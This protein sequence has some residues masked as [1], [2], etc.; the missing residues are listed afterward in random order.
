MFLRYIPVLLFFLVTSVAAQT[1]LEALHRDAVVVDG[2]NDIL[3]RVMSGGEMESRSTHGHSDLPRFRQGGLDV[4]VFSVWVPSREKGDKAW[5]FALAEIDTLHAIARRNAARLSVVTS[6]A[7]L[8]D[9]VARGRLAGIIG[10]EGGRC[11][12]GRRERI[13]ALYER[14]LRSF[15]LTWNYSSDWATCSKDESAGTVRGGLSSKGKEFVRLLDSL[16]VLIDVSHLGEKSFWDV[17]ATTRNPVYASHSA[18]SALRAHHR[19]LT[20][21][22]LRALAK[23]GGV[24]MI[25]FYPGFIR[26]GLDRERVRRSR[27]LLEEQ[28]ALQK[29][30][31]R[32]GSGY[33]SAVD[34][35]VA[36]AEAEGLA[37]V[38]TVADHIDHAVRVAGI[39]HVG[40]GSDFDGI[41]FTPIGL[42]DVSDLPVLTREL[43]RRGYS[44][45]DIRAILGGNF[46]RI[47]RR[48]CGS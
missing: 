15:G 39:A 41:S 18:C 30:H 25:N 19:N 14:G 32:R 34:A 28:A 2:H 33:I 26:S 4:Q 29:V 16:G 7:A 42:A 23:N 9:A 3:G 6:A 48:V 38:R 36:R 17:L 40:L 22:Q 27:A 13:L 20:D 10:L 24:V 47:F 5:R 45:S 12:D 46:L 37:T 11:I 43:R 44:D 1:N 8:H 31:P 35:L 21:T